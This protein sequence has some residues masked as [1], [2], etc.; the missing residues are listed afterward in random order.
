YRAVDEPDARGGREVAAGR[1][2]VTRGWDAVRVTPLDP[3]DPSDL[4]VGA[5]M[6]ARA[7]VRLGSLTPDDVKVE[8]YAGRL[9][10]HGD[11][12]SAVT[13]PMRLVKQEGKDACIYESEPVPW[14]SSGLYGYTIRVLPCHPSLNTSILP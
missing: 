5:P 13:T 1:G 12:T 11:I 10:S 4:Q 8:L 7:R 9:D 14:K 6:Q 3:Q 2:R